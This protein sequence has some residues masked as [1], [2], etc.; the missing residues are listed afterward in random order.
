[1][2]LLVKIMFCF[3][4]ETK[5]R[6]RNFSKSKLRSEPRPRRTSNREP[7]RRKKSIF[8]PRSWWKKSN[9]IV[10]FLMK[11]CAEI[12]CASADHK[13]HITGHAEPKSYV[14]ASRSTNC[15]CLMPSSGSL[16]PWY[17][18]YVRGDRIVETVKLF[19]YLT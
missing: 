9:D 2:F 19:G 11:A 17:E 4:K 14:R 5:R 12:S 15:F 16:E 8:L 7:S 18:Q 13:T 10:S 3:L 1:M 6:Q